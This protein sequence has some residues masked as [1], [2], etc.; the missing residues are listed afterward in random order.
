MP[1]GWK[2]RGREEGRIRLTGVIGRNRGDVFRRR[3][4]RGLGRGGSLSGW[5]WRLGR[6]GG[7]EVQAESV[8]LFWNEVVGEDPV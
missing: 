5:I 1:E 2:E 7:G 4:R 3:P 6:R 8:V